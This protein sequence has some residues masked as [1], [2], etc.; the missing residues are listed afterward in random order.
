MTNE[1]PLADQSLKIGGFTHLNWNVQERICT[2]TVPPDQH[3]FESLELLWKSAKWLD[4]SISSAGGQ[5][6][7]AEKVRQYKFLGQIEAVQK[8][9]EGSLLKIQMYEDKPEMITI[10]LDEGTAE[11]AY[12]Q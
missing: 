4:V 12:K 10:N 3:S 8:T 11:S 2:I 7:G 5:I 9:D 6:G 1:K